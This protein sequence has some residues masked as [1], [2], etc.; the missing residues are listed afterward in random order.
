MLDTIYSV[1]YN[2]NTFAIIDIIYGRVYK[3]FTSITKR[4]GR[5]EAF[6]KVKITKAIF[7]AAETTNILPVS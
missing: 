7:K 1:L 3:M 2:D 4:D 5:V 6:D